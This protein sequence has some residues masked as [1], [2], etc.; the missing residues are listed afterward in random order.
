MM[1]EQDGV[2]SGLFPAGDSDLLNAY[3][4]R[5]GR[6]IAYQIPFES[7]AAS[8]D[9]DLGSEDHLTS[10]ETRPNHLHSDQVGVGL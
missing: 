2:M 8:S 6:S 7:R 3:R 4:M 5:G 1:H 9:N 10:A